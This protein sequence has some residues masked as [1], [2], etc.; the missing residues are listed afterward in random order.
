[1]V[2][3]EKPV[4]DPSFS[5]ERHLAGIAIADTAVLI[6]YFGDL[7]FAHIA[8]VAHDFNDSKWVES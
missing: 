8:V 7:E 1:M 2:C 3:P 5:I 4:S 6:R